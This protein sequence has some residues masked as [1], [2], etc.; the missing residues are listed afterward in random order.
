MKRDKIIAAVGILIVEDRLLL[1]KRSDNDR[2]FPGQWCFPGG[3]MDPGETLKEACV[4]EFFEETGI[5]VE[6]VEQVGHVCGEHQ[7]HPV[8][9]EVT[10]YRVKTAHVGDIVLSP[11]E[12][13]DS[14]WVPLAEVMNMDLA[15][16]SAELLGPYLASSVT[17]LSFQ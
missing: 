7:V 13:Q 2:A 11:N 8:Q 12:H 9:V 15:G 5:S 10:S 16:K 3:K 6:V 4:R 1:L 17:R 14:A